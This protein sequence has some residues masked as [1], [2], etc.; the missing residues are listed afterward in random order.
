LR[1]AARDQRKI[2]EAEGENQPAQVEIAVHVGY[3][4]KKPFSFF[5][6]Q[7]D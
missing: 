3:A 6:N 5:S 1:S 7:G 2:R 4:I